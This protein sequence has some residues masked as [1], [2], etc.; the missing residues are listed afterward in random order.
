MRRIHI[1]ALLVAALSLH[2]RADAATLNGRTTTIFGVAVPSVT[3]EIRDN[4]TGA[5]LANPITNATGNYSA[6]LP[7]GRYDISFVPTIASHVFGVTRNGFRVDPPTTTLNVQLAPGQILSGQILTPAGAAVGHVAL[8][9]AHPF[10]GTPPANAVNAVTDEAGFVNALVSPGAW[11]VSGEPRLDQGI[12]PRILGT[13]D[14]STADRSLGIANMLPG[15]V[16]TGRIRDPLSAPL[17]SAEFYV[18]DATTGVEL[19][20]PTDLTNAL[21]VATF[22]IP[23]GTYDITAV[24]PLGPVFASFTRREV[25][26]N[27]ALDLGDITLPSGLNLLARCV[28]SL[29]TPVSGV[30]C[31]V[32]NLPSQLRLETPN[33]LSDAVGNVSVVVTPGPL[34]VSFLPA[35][36]T[37]L[38]PVAFD[39]LNVT[40]ATDL[41]NVVLADGHL[42]SVTV[43]EAGTGLPIAGANLDFIDPATGVA[44]LTL[45]DITD[46]AG[47]ARVLTARTAYNLL[48]RSPSATWNNTT[49]LN[50]RTLND[51]ALVVQLVNPLIVAPPLVSFGALA[52][53]ITACT[54]TRT[55][56]VVLDRSDATPI[57]AYSVTVQLSPE[58]VA[59][60]GT[61]AFADAGFMPLGLGDD[62]FFSVTDNGSGSYT[63][64]DVVL[65]LVPC[66]VTSTTGA[67]FN[68]LLAGGVP[69]GTGQVTITNVQLRDCANTPLAVNLGGPASVRIAPPLA[70][71]ETHV[72]VACFGGLTGT[73]DLTVSGGTAPYAYVW[74]NAATTQD[75]AGLGSGSY[76]VIVTDDD[77]CTSTLVVTLTQPAAALSLTET[78]TNPLC[79]GAL[80]GS[81]DLS[82]SGG[83]A[84]YSYL[85]NNAAITQDLT[86]LAAGGY[87]VTVTDAN[88]CSALLAVTLTQPAALVATA[89]A[90]PVACFG[91]ATGTVTLAVSGGTAGYAFLWS[92]G[93]TTQN[94]TG[95]LAGSYTVTVTDSHGCTASASATVIQPAS[96]LLVSE[97][98]V[99]LACFGALTGSIDL[100]VSGGTAGYSY[101]WSNGA[102][103]QDL[104]NLGA[105]SYSLTVTD[106]A[107]CTS[108]LSVTL[109]QPAAALS[110]TETHLNP[111]CFGALTGSIDLSVSG[112]TAPYSYLWSNSATTQDLAGI[113]AGSYSVTVTDA[114]GCGAVLAVSLTQPLALLATATA[115]PAACF[116]GTD[117][118]VTLAVSGGTAPYVFVWSN[119][120]TTQDIAAL[121]AGSYTVTVIDANNCTVSTS[122]TVAQPALLVAV[123]TAT[124]V[125]CFGAATGT[126]T[127][128][129][130][131]G[132]AGYSYLWSNGATTQNLSGL[133]AGGYSVTVTDAHGCIATAAATV[134]QPAS[135]LLVSET[136][137]TTC[138]TNPDGTIDV[139]VAG[140][141]SPYTYLWS[142]GAT[143]QDLAGLSAGTYSV[144]V[145]DAAGCPASLSATVVL[146]TFTITA[147]AGAGGSIAPPGV[148][149]VGCGASQAY[150][151]TA[152]TGFHVASVLLDGVTSLGPVSSF[153]LS[154]VLADRT[155][156]VTFAVNAPVPAISTL[157]AVQ[158]RKGNDT[159]GT[160]K[161]KLTWS[162]VAPGSQVEVW[163]APFGNYP[164]YDDGPTP[165][166][167]PTLPVGYPPAG[168]TSTAVAASGD[169]DEPAARDF[170]YYIAYVTDGLGS[171]SPVSNM[172]SGA[173]NYHLGDVS[174][175]VVALTGDNTVN[176][177]DVAELGRHYGRS[178]AAV[179]AF[180]YLDVGPT[181]DFSATARPT[182]D[183]FI[184][185][186]DLVVFAINYNPA[187]SIAVPSGAPALTDALTLEAPTHVA[188]GARVTVHLQLSGTG[189]VQALSAAL[190]WNPAVVRLI[191]HETGELV[192]RLDGVLL[193]ARPG[194]LDGAVFASSGTGFVGEGEFATLDFEVVAPGEPG[195]R[196][197]SV[198]ARD[199]LNARVDLTSSTHAAAPRETA[200]APASPNPFAHATT[201]AFALSQRGPANLMI[202]SVDGRR[203]RTLLDGVQEPGEYRIA[204]DGR[205]D[206][207]RVMPPG[208]YYA[209]LTTS[210]GRLA[211]MV[212]LLR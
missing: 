21:G 99:N 126:V 79:F 62:N 69:A 43:R 26:V 25:L 68:I 123:A 156:A 59:S 98:H 145:T 108:L 6:T 87:S 72:N 208:V 154:D 29:G 14:L 197:A 83:T 121:A 91:G 70:L 12:A 104:A 48:V 174:G 178:G 22:V 44:A 129:V 114:N 119:G 125:A 30:E 81:I 23:A 63:V 200:F 89:T 3:V 76:S 28:N 203:V 136:H 27:S 58:L 120:E 157:A 133:L 117:G 115:T 33:N 51:T 77:G 199:A 143:T 211:R 128:A 71:T 170:W 32:N 148:T 39:P 88:G 55:L 209:R 1:A 18:K 192:T 210:H 165:G 187:V 102:T 52:G 113:G 4:G 124:P 202:Y 11:V 37:R 190:D 75:L 193:S 160:T 206:D 82:V 131:G 105:G 186:D 212:T 92:N 86:G 177:V 56:P 138:A 54:P 201:L 96:A 41:G 167:T 207:G 9:F 173:L 159:D 31:V 183:N 164:E 175:R 80:N 16:V 2:S 17:P 47:F 147:S 163:R 144:T 162:G 137:T 146:R 66:G 74:S 15:F 53:A 171:R 181:T 152:E 19:Y 132:T 112:G 122:A 60:G 103:T 158:L 73:I 67:L 38:V 142:N 7:T 94:L 64:D 93:A 95:L 139:T 46:A 20:T 5:L 188:A 151:I 13:F 198:D 182:T 189:R 149:I 110:L 141:T 36:A 85:W 10:L 100:T 191:S 107:G 40:S 90:T 34:R 195:F 24:P 169:F 61:V 150:T 168:W 127:L 101:L 109:T 161:I 155:V 135:A 57:K 140:G 184:N 65:T 179:A 106:A 176:T 116:G 45:G 172:T 166:S 194:L 42:V 35:P 8:K 134:T 185:F 196:I 50:F 118:A 204:W 78:H 97:T 205:G 49:I 130:S 153:I 84:P 180:A 111:L